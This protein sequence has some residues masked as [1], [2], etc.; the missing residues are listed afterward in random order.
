[1]SAH[2]HTLFTTESDRAHG[3]AHAGFVYM[4]FLPERGGDTHPA[5]QCCFGNRARPAANGRAGIMT[6][7]FV[8]VSRSNSG[9]SSGSVLVGGILI[10][11]LK[12]ENTLGNNTRIK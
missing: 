4:Q 10:S 1:M 7:V 5:S 8:R 12:E 11:S 3:A 9:V 2:S 6:C